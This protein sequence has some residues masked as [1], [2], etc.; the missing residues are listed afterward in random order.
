M[1]SSE[2]YLSKCQE[3]FKRYLSKHVEIINKK[4]CI[5]VKGCSY[6][7]KHKIINTKSIFRTRNRPLGASIK[8][9]Y[10]FGKSVKQLILSNAKEISTVTY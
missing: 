4:K 3:I 5:D 10:K 7:H 6:I 8:N 1:C 9:E 2:R